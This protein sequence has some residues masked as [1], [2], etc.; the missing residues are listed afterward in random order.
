MGGTGGLFGSQKW[1]SGD[2]IHRQQGPRG[3]PLFFW[4][5]WGDN[6]VETEAAMRSSQS[7]VTA[8]SRDVYLKVT[9]VEVENGSRKG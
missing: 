7:E 6:S 3:E 2:A 4:T 1:V 8:C 5:W 9:D